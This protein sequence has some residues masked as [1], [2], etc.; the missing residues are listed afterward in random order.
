MNEPRKTFGDRAER[1]AQ[2]TLSAAT[3]AA[4]V[5]VI[6]NL[7]GIDRKFDQLKDGLTHGI[8]RAGR[9]NPFLGQNPLIGEHGADGTQREFAANIVDGVM[10]AGLFVALGG[11]LAMM[12]VKGHQVSHWMQ[13][14]THAPIDFVRGLTGAGE[15][16]V[17]Q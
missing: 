14:I 16:Q 17:G 11:V 7:P 12:G 15:R 1:V 9:N 10:E 3:M 8:T 2:M 6:T 13:R 4:V 5:G